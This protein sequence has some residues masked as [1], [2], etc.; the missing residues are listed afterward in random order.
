VGRETGAWL[1]YMYVRALGKASGSGGSEVRKSDMADSVFVVCQATHAV[2]ILTV[3][4]WKWIVASLPFAMSSDG[5]VRNP[6]AICQC[7]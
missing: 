3:W 5:V 4:D 6:S 2:R 1:S 7:Q